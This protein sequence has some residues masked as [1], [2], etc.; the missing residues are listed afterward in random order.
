ME[1]TEELNHDYDKNSVK[2]IS[3]IVWRLWSN[4]YIEN[5][6]NEKKKAITNLR[7]T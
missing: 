4:L 6:A 7:K 3:R 2:R 1:P 5:E